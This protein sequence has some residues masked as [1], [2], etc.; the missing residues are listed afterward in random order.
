MVVDDKD[1]IGGGRLNKKSSKSK[2]PAFLTIDARQTFT[3][4][5][6]T[7]TKAP[8]FSN[9]DLK[10]HIRIERMLPVTP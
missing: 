3:Q 9:F 8:I 5:R 1:I 7:F 10:R 4:L 2:N 6:Q